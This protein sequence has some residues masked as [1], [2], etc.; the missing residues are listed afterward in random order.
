VSDPL[1]GYGSLPLGEPD[2]GGQSLAYFVSA[3]GFGHA[4]R[5]CAVMAALRAR[6]PDVTLHVFTQAPEWLF[7]ESVPGGV[8]YHSA[9]TD[10]G[11]VQHDALSEDLPA[12]VERLDALLPFDP[13]LVRHWADWLRLLRCELVVC[14]IAPLGLAVAQAAELPSVLIENFTWDWIYAP[15]LAAEPRFARH[16]AALRDAVALATYHLQAE[17]VCQPNPTANGRLP[18]IGRPPRQARAATRAALRLAEHE[19]LVLVT[20]GGMAG[21]LPLPRAGDG[22]ADV[23][24]VLPGSSD[25]LR[26]DGQRLSLPSHSAFYHPDLIHASDAVVGK[27]GYSTVVEA[28]QAGV[29]FGYVP[30]AGFRESPVMAAFVRTHLPSVEITAEVFQAGGWGPQVAELLEQP[31]RPPGGPN[32]ADVAADYLARWLG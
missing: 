12:T 32:G 3:H 4:T 6:R 18:P 25:A 30:R 9:A 27:L 29:P 13:H 19:R 23:V 14:D 8:S 16:M 11:V 31:S 1:A 26:R 10:V 28:Y 22:P 2:G 21:D 5:A 24:Y 7:A 15:Y 17:P 20:L